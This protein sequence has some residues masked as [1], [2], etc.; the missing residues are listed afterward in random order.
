M[1]KLSDDLEVA[2]CPHCRVDKPNLPMLHQM[3]TH[4]HGGE[5]RRRWRVYACKRCGGV[6]VAWG[7][8][9]GGPVAQV[10][11]EVA[12]VAEEIPE[13][14]R[15]YLEQANSSLHAPAG[16]VM[17]AAASVDEMLKEKGLAE[18]SLD[19]RIKKAVEDHLITSEM[20]KWAHEVR[21][22]AN[23][24][25]HADRKATLP[26]EGDA[27]R[28]VDFTSALGSFLFVLPARVTRGIAAA[29]SSASPP[30][31]AGR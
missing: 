9:F 10:F 16:A 11:P 28:V 21:L 29:E 18:G 4:S 6:V 24:Q 19:A 15:S 8:E 27:K 23:D 17:L 2:R 30:A 26:T 25:R 1:S 20:A 12:G 7:A 22:D 31:A 13:R 3:E 14:A 5:N